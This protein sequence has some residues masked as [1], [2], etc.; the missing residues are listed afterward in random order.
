VVDEVS[1]QGDRH[2]RRGW[3]GD[4]GREGLAS[5]TLFAGIVGLAAP[6]RGL[7]VIIR[8]R[9]HLLHHWTIGGTG[10]ARL[11]RCNSRCAAD[12]EHD[13]GQ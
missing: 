6:G 8:R 2:E 12:H 10:I 13:R 9:R 5:E 3:R 7:R 4:G 11:S 1:A